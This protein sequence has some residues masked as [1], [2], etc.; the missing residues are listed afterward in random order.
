MFSQFAA[1]LKENNIFFVKKNCE[2][3][4]SEF[5]KICQEQVISLRYW[6]DQRFTDCV[7]KFCE[8]ER[9]NFITELAP[10]WC[11]TTT[12]LEGRNIDSDKFSTINN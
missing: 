4:D 9:I 7:V 3:V 6:I 10:M 12:V 11:L 5:V 2:F 8:F 1:F